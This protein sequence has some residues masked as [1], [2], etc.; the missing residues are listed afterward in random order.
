MTY[1]V[2]GVTVTDDNID[3]IMTTALEGG[4]NYW[5]EWV[6]P[7]GEYLGEYASDQISR[8]GK[9]LFCLEEAFD[10]DGTYLYAMTRDDFLYGLEL[11]MRDSNVGPGGEIDPCTIDACDADT[12]VQYALWGEL[13]FG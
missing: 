10:N 13:V 11:W 5:C 9:L 7:E 3:D 12:I 2:N 1:E 8:G 6:R 4:I